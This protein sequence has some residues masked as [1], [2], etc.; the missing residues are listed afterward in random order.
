MKM[1]S[2]QFSLCW[3]NFHRN[4]SMGMQ[5]LLENEVLVDVTL[6][7]E[8]RYL[9]AHKMV[10]SVCSP[11]FRELFQ[12]NPCKHPIV[13]MKDVSYVVL[14]DLLQFMYQG[15]VQVAQENLSLFIKTAE[16]L[17]IKGLTGDN[18]GQTNAE[19][20]EMETA[21]VDTKKATSRPKK[22]SG[23]ASKK[24]KLNPIAS[25]H[26]KTLPVIS[27]AS[28]FEVTSVNTNS[29]VTEDVS[30]F[31]PEPT[32]AANEQQSDTETMNDSQIDQY[33]D[34]ANAEDNGDDGDDFSMAD[35]T[36]D[37]PKAS[38]STDIGGG[39]D[40][41][42]FLYHSRGQKHPKLLLYGN[43]FVFERHMADKTFWKCASYPRTKCRA[44]VISTS[45]N[46][47]TNSS[48]HNHSP[49]CKSPVICGE[50]KALKLM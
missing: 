32:E 30:N 21:A 29:E 13:F 46:V 28:K 5:S 41:Q 16:A 19:S 36:I 27:S 2:E 14:M 45:C 49:N 26:V 3:D 43:N 7:I 25:S 39:S 48:L 4:M 11:Y 31:K 38:T 50:V 12:S 33:A 44:R 9:K 23:P 35:T 1:A 42:G 15:E 47:R 8:G 22:F 6:A 20:E 40:N 18:E 10:L 37:E 24:P 34:Y 17:Q